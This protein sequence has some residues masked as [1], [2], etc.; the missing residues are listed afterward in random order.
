MEKR[1]QINGQNFDYMIKENGEIFSLKTNKILKGS[2]TPSGYKYYR[3]KLNGETY[4][5]YA[6]VLMAI[7]FLN[8]NQEK[9]Y[10]VNH[11][12][13][14]KLNNNIKNLEV[15]TQKENMIHA[16]KN[17]L[18]SKNRERK[19]EAI[20]LPNEEWRMVKDFPKYAV[21]NFG[22]VKSFQ[23][24]IPIILKPSLTNGYFKVRLTNS[25]E[26]KDFLVA[27][28]VYF[29][30]NPE[31]VLQKN[32]VIDHINGEKT[33]NNLINLRYISVAEN[34]IKAI[35]EQ[36]LNPSKKAVGLLNEEGQIIKIYPSC[37][38]AGEELGLDKSSIA[39]V[40]RGDYQSTKGYKFCYIK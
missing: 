33:D 13:G 23:R 12:D 26:V 39:H 32:F 9:G 18:I 15:I 20:D 40:C 7:C 16:N 28:L 22:R 38:K 27:Y 11:I 14:D 3:L 1:I 4:R 25:N 5:F 31:V 35:Y 21:S 17:N 34:T 24:E 37:S 30:F 6:Q 36:N 29:T 19:K 10:V 2:I 8:Y